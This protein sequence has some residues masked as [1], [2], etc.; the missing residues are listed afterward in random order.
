M[1]KRPKRGKYWLHKRPDSPR[2]YIASYDPGRRKTRLEPTGTQSRVEAEALLAARYEAE[3]APPKPAR[4]TTKA[5]PLPAVAV[6]SV[7]DLF[8]KSTIR[9]APVQASRWPLVSDILDGYVAVLERDDAP[10]AVTARY[11]AARIKAWSPGLTVEELEDVEVQQDYVTTRDADGVASSTIARELSVLRAALRWHRPPEGLA[12]PRIYPTDTSATRTRWLAQEEAQRLLAACKTEHLRLFVQIALGT[13]ARPGAIF[14]L[15]WSAADLRGGV[16]DFGRSGGGNDRKRRPPVRIPEFLK[17]ELRIVRGGIK[18]DGPVI[19]YKGQGVRSVRTAFS[20]AVALAGLGSD[21]T[22]YTLRHTAATWAAMAGV[23]LWDIAHMLG[24]STTRMVERHYAH[25][26]PDFQA[27][28]ARVLDDAMAGITA[29]AP[30]LH[31]RSNAATTRAKAKKSNK[32]KVVGAT[33]IEL[34]TPTMST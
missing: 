14:D 22:P 34:V 25:F 24:H 32:N 28:T 27:R 21:V 11:N 17:T 19:E 15:H 23:P 10:G 18:V 4:K 33:R 31:P 16:I 2:W 9:S 1:G 29:S 3:A 7:P 8:S 20:D 26:H 30:Q 12:P 13:G 6:E 5:P